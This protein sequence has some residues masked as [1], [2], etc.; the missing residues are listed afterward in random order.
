MPNSKN[1]K[2]LGN[3]LKTST[4]A[5]AKFLSTLLETLEKNGVDINDE[6]ILK[7]LNLNLDLTNGEQFVKGL[8]A[9]TVVVTIVM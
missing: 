9:S 8:A 2:A 5:R 1:L 7:E 4:A 3:R 6:T